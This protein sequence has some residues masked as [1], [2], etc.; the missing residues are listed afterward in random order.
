[1][2]YSWLHLVDKS[3]LGHIT[4]GMWFN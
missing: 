4:F 1:M 2:V 3:Y